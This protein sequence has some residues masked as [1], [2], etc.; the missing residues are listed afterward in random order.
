LDPDGRGERGVVEKGCSVS[1]E[2]TQPRPEHRAE[3]G[4]V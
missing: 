2:N 1:P 3:A 4:G